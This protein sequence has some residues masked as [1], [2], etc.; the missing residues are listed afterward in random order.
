MGIDGAL[1]DVP[2]FSKS[3]SVQDCL[4]NFDRVV[5]DLKHDRLAAGLSVAEA[6]PVAHAT[7]TSGSTATSS[8]RSLTANF[9]SFTGL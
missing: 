7:T 2:R 3:E 6:A 4:Q 1:L 9:R 8:Q 5:T